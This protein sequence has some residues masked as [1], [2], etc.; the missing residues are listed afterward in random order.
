MIDFESERERLNK[1]LKFALPE[2]TYQS[3]LTLPLE[4]VTRMFEQEIVHGPQGKEVVKLMSDIN[5][6]LDNGNLFTFIISFLE[7]ESSDSLSY[8]NTVDA[9]PHM[10]RMYDIYEQRALLFPPVKRVTFYGYDSHIIWNS[11]QPD[12]QKNSASFWA[13][14]FLDGTTKALLLRDQIENPDSQMTQETYDIL[15]WQYRKTFG[16]IHPNDKPVS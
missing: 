15:T 2:E 7:V 14:R 1:R 6:M 13:K 16:V 12:E 8:Q 5:K 11:F 4:Y 3:S 10:S 9:L